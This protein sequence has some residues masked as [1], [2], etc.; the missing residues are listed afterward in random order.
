MNTPYQWFGGKASVAGEIWRRLG[1]VG[2]FSDPFFGGGAVLLNRPDWHERQIETINDIDH[3][4]VNFWRSL[5]AVPDEVAHHADWPVT[6]CDLTA[7]HIWLV[8]EGRQRIAHLETDPDAYDAKVA[9][10][11]VWGLCCWIGSGWCSGAGPWTAQNGQLVKETGSGGVSR[12]LPHL[13]DA[14]QGVKRQLPHLGNAGR[15]ANR[16]SIDSLLAYM[17]ALAERLRRVRVCCGD[18]RRILTDGA[19][20]HGTTVGVLLD[21]PYSHTAGRDNTLYNHDTDISA[22]VRAWAIEHGDNKRFRIALCSYE[23]EH[24]MPSSWSVYK[25]KSQGGMANNGNGDNQNKH[26]ERIW[27]SPHCLPPVQAELFGEL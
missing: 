16:A 25:W 21:P 22:D 23:G 18:W 6:E 11:W 14:G 5:A 27:F 7:R 4:V 26:R 3:Y 8:T 12:Q 10:W 17:R 20:A 2:N 19:L 15:G 13:G 9:G 24:V 1:D